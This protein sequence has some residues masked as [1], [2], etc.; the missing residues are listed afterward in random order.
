MF[1]NLLDSESIKQEF[2]LYTHINNLYGKLFT[3]PLKNFK[4]V[5]IEFRDLQN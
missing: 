2:Q 4:N 3:K 1:F 5:K